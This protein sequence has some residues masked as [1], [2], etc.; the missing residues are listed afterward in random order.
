MFCSSAV[1][2]GDC[3]LY[4]NTSLNRIECLLD[5]EEIWLLYQGL[6]KLVGSVERMNRDKIDK[7]PKDFIV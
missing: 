5:L 2:C 6:L 7:I 3:F 1:T 4:L